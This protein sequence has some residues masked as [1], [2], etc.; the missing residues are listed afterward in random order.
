[1]GIEADGTII[2]PR[3]I[4]KS[5]G[6]RLIDARASSMTI[7]RQKDGSNQ[8]IDLA[9]LW[10]LE[11][12][13][14]RLVIDADRLR[15]FVEKLPDGALTIDF[16]LTSEDGEW[17]CAGYIP[18]SKP[19]GSQTRSKGWEPIRKILCRQMD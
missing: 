11:P 16:A 8:V 9:F 6:R 10:R 18:I 12:R 4:F 2:G 14:N 17:G 5:T 13:A 15:P 1:M 19:K 3:L 7:F